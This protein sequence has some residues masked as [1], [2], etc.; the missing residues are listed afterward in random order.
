MKSRKFISCATCLLLACG[1]ANAHDFVVV[2]EGQKVYFNVKSEKNRTA[3]VTYNG[4]IANGRPTYYEGELAVPGKVKHGNAVYDVVG[5]SAK[6]FSGA[7]KLTSIVLPSGITS[8]GD[9]AFEGCVSLSKIIFPGNEVQFGQ[10][11]FFKCGKIQYV[12]L[13][14]DWKSVDLKMFRWSDSLRVMTIPA[15][16]E[17][18][19]NLKS[20]KNLE[21]MSVDINNARFS[22]IEGILYDKG[23]EVLYG[24]PRAYDGRL[25]VAAGTKKITAGAF[26]GCGSIV[27]VDC[28]ESLTSVSFR[29][30]AGLPSLNEIVFRGKEPVMTARFNGSDVFL[31]QVQNPGVKIIVQKGAKNNYQSAIIQETGEYFEIDGTIPYLV[32]SDKMVK[33]KNVVGVKNFKKYE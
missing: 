11:V 8:I 23:G 18:I 3:E 16:I 21:S 7:D 24:C 30:F 4:S 9:F 10:G 22:A 19:S 6:A 14:S 29:E 26:S 25:H 12:S 28:P 1:V 2:V 5:I 31:L 27:S 17:R 33:S 20:L 13:G 32:E 15:K